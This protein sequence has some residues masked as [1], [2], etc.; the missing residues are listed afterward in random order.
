MLSAGERH[1]LAVLRAMLGSP[2]L[3]LLDEPGAHLDPASAA[4]VA[5]LLERRAEG[6]T[7]ILVSH[8][9]S[10]LNPGATRL[11]VIG[12]SRRHA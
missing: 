12:W 9:A 10:E 1:R 5:R 11:E 3:L 4:M 6:I 2:R 7:R 8:E